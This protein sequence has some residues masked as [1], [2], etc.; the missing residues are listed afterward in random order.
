MFIGNRNYNFNYAK[1]YFQF[2]KLILYVGYQKHTR[3]GIGNELKIH[4][5]TYI[6]FENFEFDIS[7]DWESLYNKALS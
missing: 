6:K 3:I 7:R 4:N 5:F 1:N 2:N